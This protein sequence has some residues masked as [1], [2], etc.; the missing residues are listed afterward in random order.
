MLALVVLVHALCANE[1]KKESKNYAPWLVQHYERFFLLSAS[2]FELSVRRHALR[3]L[4]HKHRQ[5]LRVPIVQSGTN[6]KGYQFKWLVV[7]SSRVEQAKQQ[8]PSPFCE[9]PKRLCVL[10]VVRRQLFYAFYGVSLF[11]IGVFSISSIHNTDGSA[12]LKTRENLK[13]IFDKKRQ[14]I[15]KLL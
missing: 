11:S 6:N 1:G 9:V 15:V 3:C 12:F 4:L 5:T 10:A 7:F 2:Y 13:K 8:R 14:E